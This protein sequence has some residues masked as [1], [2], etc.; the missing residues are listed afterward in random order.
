MRVNRV[1][2][3]QPL[4]EQQ[5]VELEPGAAHHLA[6]V[7]RSRSGD[8][9]VLFNGDGREYNGVLV[10]VERRRVSARID[11]SVPGRDSQRL[12]IE[13]GIG[14]S[15]GDRFDWVVQKAT[16]LGVTVIQPLVTERCEVRLDARREERKLAHWQQVLVAASEQSGRSRLPEFRTPVD[17]RSWTSHVDAE[18]KLLLDPTGEALKT[19]ASTPNRL[20]LLIGPEG[21]FSDEER[22]RAREDGF[23]PVRLGTR[24]LRTET[25]PVTALSVVQWLWGDFQSAD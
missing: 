14:L 13:L 6:T 2:T 10:D 25:A 23:E 19:G 3:S 17:L 22:A 9:V 24:I 8:P 5:L 11:G 7:L 18:R 4:A 20:A 15:R 21:G 12:A 1:Y 16:E